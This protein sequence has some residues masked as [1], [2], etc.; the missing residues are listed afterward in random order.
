[1]R[2]RYRA[3]AGWPALAWLATLRR[4]SDVIE[5]DH[6][7]GVETRPDW[8]CEAVWPGDFAA[9]DFDLTDL[10][11]GSGGRLRDDGSRLVLVPSGSTVDRIAWTEHADAIVVSNSLPAI[12]ERTHGELDPVADRYGSLFGTIASGL[13]AYVRELPTSAGAVH[14]Q[15]FHDL[16]WD[17]T[18]LTEVPKPDSAPDGFDTFETYHAFLTRNL[19]AIAANAADPDRGRPR[20]LVGTI[21]SGYDSAAVAIL[22]QAIGLREVVSCTVGRHGGTDSGAAIATVVGLET[23]PLDR[24]R[25]RDGDRP[26]IPFIAANARGQDIFLAGAGARLTGRV[27]LTGFHGDHAW[28]TGSDHLGPDIVRKDNSGLSLTEYR[29]RADVIHLPVPFMGIRHVADLHRIGRSPA[30]AAWSVGGDYDRPIARRIIEGAGVARGTFATRKSVSTVRYGT[31]V[32]SGLSGSTRR[33]LQHWLHGQARS[34]RAAGR[35]PPT[36]VERVSRPIRIA[37]RVGGPIDRLARSAPMPLPR[38]RA[39]GRRL[40][41]YSWQEPLAKW[42]FP[43][44]MARAQEAYREP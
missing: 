29:L 27:L 6:G 7:P 24:G 25:W 13:D 9:G 39:F 40:V 18:R 31:S 38:V 1:M 21:S 19:Q 35:M 17:G 42:A 28:A 10:V 11:F 12:L 43:W 36:Y 32:G 8:F 23:I 22:G 30:M 26:E 5:V 34:F 41:H 16:H 4:S 44:A 3:V 15:Y 14:L 37:A 33:D 2:L 20:S